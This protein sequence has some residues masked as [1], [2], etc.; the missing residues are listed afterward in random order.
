MT[1][2]SKLRDLRLKNGLT[3]EELADRAE[4]SKGFIS[5]LENDLTSPSI[6][7]LIDI[8]TLL[9][10]NLSSFF[11]DYDDSQLV[12][13]ESD[14]FEK[15]Y[16][17]MTVQWIV[18]TAQKNAMEPIITELSK[19]ASTDEDFPHEGEEFGY[20]LQ[21]KVRVVVGERTAEA[22]AGDTFYFSADKK[23]YIVN[24]YDGV[25]KVLWVSC[26]PSF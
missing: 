1:I 22:K 26:P 13:T 23:H 9:G 24:V 5:Q 25:S 7:T 8:L 17:D 16:D 14:Y 15:K 18:P 3:Q 10:S 20:V 11:A 4:L 6:A 12:F 19:G 2:G 21:G